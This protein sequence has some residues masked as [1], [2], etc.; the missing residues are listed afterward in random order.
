[1]STRTGCSAASAMLMRK[2]KSAHGAELRRPGAAATSKQRAR[3]IACTDAHR[4]RQCRA[5]TCH[6][7][8]ILAY[9]H[10]HAA[11]SYDLRTATGK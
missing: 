3:S 10:V 7:C 6:F 11:T 9:R 4:P 1:M 5:D 8:D 2:G